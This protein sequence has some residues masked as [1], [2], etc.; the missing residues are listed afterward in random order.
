VIVSKG[1]SDEDQGYSALEAILPDGASLVDALHAHGVRH[2]FVGGLATDYCVR[3]TVL[4]ALKNG[5]ATSVLIDAS[6]PVEAQAGDGERALNEML[7]AG[8][9]PQIL[10]EFEPKR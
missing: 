7:A 2:V 8:A 6:R 4:D 9:E 5:F 1:M 3:A 10:D